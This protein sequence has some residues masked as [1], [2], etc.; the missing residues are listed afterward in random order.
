MT[1]SYPINQGLYQSSYE[2][3][4]C[5]IGFIAHIKG[6]KSH[7]IIHHGL[8]ALERMTHR[9]AEGA[10]KTTGDGAGIMIQIPPLFNE[11]I[12]GLPQP[13]Q[14]GTGLVFLPQKPKEAEYCQSMLEGTLNAEGLE[15]IAW[16]HVPVDSA[17]LGKIARNAEPVIQQIFVKVRQQSWEQ[18]LL[19]RK[20]YIVRKQVEKQIRASGLEQAAMFY[21]PSLSSKTIVYK[22]MLMSVQLRQYFGDLQDRRLTSAIAM[23]HS[24]FSTNTFPSWRL[25]HPFRLIAHN[26]E[27][28]TIKS[29]RFW[30]QARESDFVSG[31]FGEDLEKLLPVLEPDA[32]DSASFDNV[33]ELLTMAGRSL[34]HAISM[35]IP[36]SFNKLNPIPEDLKYFYEYHSAMMEPWDGPAA[37][38]FCD[39][40]YV[41]GTLDRNGLRPSRYVITHDD[42]IVM[43]SEVGVQSF[44]PEQI[45]VKGR[46]RPGKLLLVDVEEGRIIPDEEIKDQISLQRPYPDW[47]KTNRI[48]FSEIQLNR[49]VPVSMQDDMLHTLQLTYGYSNEDIDHILLPMIEDHKEPTGSMGTDTPIA[50]FSDK[51]QRLFNYFKQMFAQVT[52]PAIDPIR[53]RLVMTLTV[54]IGREGNLLSETPGHCRSVQIKHPVLTNMDIEK[55]KDWDTEDFRSTILPMTFPIGE[56]PAGLEAALDRLCHQAEQ[57]VDEGYSSIILS[58]KYVDE[59]NAPIPS[60]LACSAVHHHLIRTKKRSKTALVIETAEAREVMHFAL[61]FGYG[62]SA[63]NPYG[64]FATIYKLFSEGR[65]STI[66]QYSEAEE[67]YLQ[68]INLG[69]LKVL[70]KLGISTLRSYH[71]AQTFEAIGLSKEL[72]ESYFPGT[73]SRIEGIGLEEIAKE[74][75]MQHQK[76][77]VEKPSMLESSGVYRYRKGGEKHAWNP[78]SIYLLQWA[79]RSNDYKKYREFSKLVNSQNQ[80]PHVLRGLLDFKQR[81]SMPIDEVEPVEEIYKRLTTGAMSFG[82]LGK[83]AHETIAIAMNTI[84]GRSNSG[85]GGEDPKRFFPHPD[86]T[87]TRSA[88]KQVASGRFG[89]SINYLANADELQIKIA[90]GAKPGEGG[91]L[92]GYKVDEIIAK[93][94]HSTPGVTLISPPPHHDIYSIEDL[95]QLIYDLKNA[96]PEARVSVKLVSEAGVGTI[97]VGVAK[98]N[99][100]TILISGYDGGTGA[101]PQS[102]IKHAGLPFELGLAEAHQTLLLNNLRGWVKLQTD[103]QLKTG[104][105]VVIAAM[106]G[107]EEFAF[108]TAALIVLGCVMMRKCHTNS[109][110]VGVATQDPRLRERFRGKPEHL[111]NYLHFVSQEI[112]EIMAELGICCFDDLIGRTDLLTMRE[113]GHW[114]AKTVDLSSIL[115]RPEI[116]PNNATHYIAR[117]VHKTEEPIDKQLLQKA[118]SALDDHAPVVIDMPIGNANRAVGARLSYEVSKR[119]GEQGLPEDTIQCTFQGSAGQS[120]GAFLAKG[121]TFRLEGDSNDYFGKGLSGGK[122]VVIPPEGSTFKPE[123][124]IIIGNTA[125]YGA[126]GGQ[127]YICGVAGERFCVRNSGV[128]AVVEGTGDHGCEYM[129]GGRVVV[130][131]HVGRNFAAGMS[132]GIAYVLNGDGDFAYFCNQSM[133]ELSPVYEQ[134]DQQFIHK[135][136]E[137]HIHY[138]GSPIAQRVLKS[139]HTFIPRFIKVMP[140]EYKRVLESQPQEPI[141]EHKWALTDTTQPSGLSIHVN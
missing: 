141:F 109:C 30:I 92:P 77:Y 42:L 134:E 16:R 97:A 90:Q 44:K 124:N 4:A 132:G 125:L 64:V 116:A 105:D 106:L 31:L 59:M 57:K 126:T 21:I 33:L 121:I 48:R 55:I 117:G 11:L 86:G 8:E 23:V 28:N 127:A 84:G 52:N 35:L 122:L 45:A 47:V 78:E 65:F 22:G 98:A 6:Q 56:G 73:D 19:E 13:G 67:N 26:G 93:T 91:Q 115:Y 10:D 112:R 103:G 80:R 46:L 12:V 7:D 100:D 20:L 104:R 40:R 140:L 87:W 82:S 70:S 15:V 119:Y 74:A 72:I 102:S 110:P 108:G 18:H 75:L 114:K 123:E 3:D 37:I 96:N 51:P 36:E 69:L 79:C 27:I 63:V 14:Y 94:R 131:G 88:I 135:L 25:A 32:S 101:S 111:I 68:A 60:L 2:H 81:S 38:V 129:T 49:F 62:A 9:G 85:E 66:T 113:V 29:N 138:T 17:V 95:K 54:Y 71:G 41:G 50:V 83:E 99:A 58:D 136:L 53:E 139:W 5:G 24:R 128:H 137:N 39:G 34:P 120:F 76:A 43:A 89:V 61:L 118:V 107:A 133:V 1:M 130:L